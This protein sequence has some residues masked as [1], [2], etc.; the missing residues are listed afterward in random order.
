MFSFLK[1]FVIFFHQGKVVPIIIFHKKCVVGLYKYLNW[2]WKNVE[3][4]ATRKLLLTK[5][6]PLNILTLQE[7]IVGESYQ[8]GENLI[9]Y[10][11]L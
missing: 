9:L 7:N 10:K 8:F 3:I 2:L 1:N 5:Q 4:Y 6:Y 11:I